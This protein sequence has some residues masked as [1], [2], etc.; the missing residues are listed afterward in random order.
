MRARW[1]DILWYRFVLVTCFLILSPLMRA[2]SPVPGSDGT[3]HY[4]KTL[5]IHESQV[6]H[7]VAQSIEPEHWHETATASRTQERTQCKTATKKGTHFTRRTKE[8]S[9]YCW[10]HQIVPDSERCKATIKAGKRCSSWA[11]MGSDDCSQHEKYGDRCHG[12][13]R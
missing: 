3:N 13:T 7:S 2:E 5:A 6:I 11:N 4:S 12:Q 1:A 8:L 10:Q 9:G